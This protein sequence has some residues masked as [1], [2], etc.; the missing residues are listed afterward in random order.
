MPWRTLDGPP[1]TASLLFVSARGQSLNRFHFNRSVWR[2][3]LI[4]AGVPLGRENG[5]HALR[6]FYASVLLDAGESIKALSECLGH[7]HPSFTLRTYTHLMP[8]SEARTRAAVDRV[9]RNPG[10]TGDGPETAQ[11]A[12]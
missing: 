2:P 4:S 6:H 12:T 9:F 8:N 7:H 1:V 5:M 10:D 11:E 3:A